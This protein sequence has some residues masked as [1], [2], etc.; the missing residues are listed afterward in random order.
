MKKLLISALIWH[1]AIA[2]LTHAS[3]LDASVGEPL[4]KSAK[5]VELSDNTKNFSLPLAFATLKL[6]ASTR[7]NSGQE[8]K[9]FQISEKYSECVDGQIGLEAATCPRGSILIS[10]MLDREGASQFKLFKTSP[11]LNWVMPDT[12]LPN[13][14]VDKPY[15][16]ILLACETSAE[17]DAGRVNPSKNRNWRFV[18]YQ[19]TITNFD[20]VKLIRL[21]DRKKYNHC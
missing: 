7:T 1:F 21:P 20:Q 5:L 4:Q 8:I 10:T 13:E 17:I 16:G 12:Q 18:E 9:I 14:I 6:I 11:R 3:E 19:L 2:N 15:I